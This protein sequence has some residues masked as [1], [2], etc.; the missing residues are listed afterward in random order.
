M[1][2]IDWVKHKK[3]YFKIMGGSNH[4]ASYTT[5]IVK[6]EIGKWISSLNHIQRRDG[7]NWRCLKR[8]AET[9]HYC[10]VAI[11]AAKYVNTAMICINFGDTISGSFESDGSQTGFQVLMRGIDQTCEEYRLTRVILRIETTAHYYED[12]VRVVTGLYSSSNKRFDN[13]GR[14][15]EDAEL[16][17]DRPR[18]RALGSQTI[19]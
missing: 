9:D 16:H 2:E 7:S 14:T 19:I 6:E 11:D 3:H 12:L 5:P 10:M 4:R 15:K 17:D 8:S 1:Y 13:S 18:N